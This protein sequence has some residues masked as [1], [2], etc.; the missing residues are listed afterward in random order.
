MTSSYEHIK[1]RS[2]VL[3]LG[4]KQVSIQSILCMANGL[5][6]FFFFFFAFSKRSKKDYICIY[7]YEYTHIYTNIP[8][9]V[10]SYMYIHMCTDRHITTIIYDS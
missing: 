5:S 2:K 9:C 7:I 8:I 4:L 6:C 3:F 1:S 10:F